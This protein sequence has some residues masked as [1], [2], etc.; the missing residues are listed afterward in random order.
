VQQPELQIRDP[1]VSLDRID[2][3]GSDEAVEDRQPVQEGQQVANLV[4]YLA[5]DAA[6]YMVGNTIN[7]AGGQ[8]MI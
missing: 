7:V 6:A 2:E 1:E 3:Q 5:S 8:S 4:A